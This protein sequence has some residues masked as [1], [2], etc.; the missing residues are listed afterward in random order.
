MDVLTESGG[1]RGNHLIGRIKGIWGDLEETIE[2]DVL[3]EFGG[4]RESHFI[5]RIQGIW[6]I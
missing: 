1:F 3:R 6:E 5:G 4:Y 2:L